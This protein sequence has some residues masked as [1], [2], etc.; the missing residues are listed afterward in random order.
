M[1]FLAVG[2]P[3]FAWDHDVKNLSLSASQESALRYYLQG[4][5][6]FARVGTFEVDGGIKK[7][8]LTEILDQLKLV[9]YGGTL[10]PMLRGRPDD[11]VASGLDFPTEAGTIDLVGALQPWRIMFCLAGAAFDSEA[12][13]GQDTKSVPASPTA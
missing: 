2:S 7:K 12:G 4:C 11:L 10:P 13:A 8:S 9:E 3:P 6:R 1:S 5:R